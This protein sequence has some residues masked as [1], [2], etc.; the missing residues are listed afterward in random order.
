MPGISREL[1]VLRIITNSTSDANSREDIAEDSATQPSIPSKPKVF[2]LNLYAS[3]INLW[4]IE[5]G[6]L[7]TKAIEE[8]PENQKIRAS[9]QNGLK[10]KEI[11]NKYHSKYA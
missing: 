11:L 3:N 2:H 1:R 10:V 5:G 4:S 7:Y 6:K 8:L 9:I